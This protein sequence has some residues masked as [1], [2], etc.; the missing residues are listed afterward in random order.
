MG[1]QGKILEI[2]GFDENCRLSERDISTI[3]T[4]KSLDKLNS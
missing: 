4:M 1:R 2:Q 3:P